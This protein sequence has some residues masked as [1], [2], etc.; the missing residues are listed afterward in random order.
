MA[1]Q[2][3]QDAVKEALSVGAFSPIG[4][5][6]TTNKFIAAGDGQVKFDAPNLDPQVQNVMAT[7]FL[8]LQDAEQTTPNGIVPRPA[9][10][11]KLQASSL[12]SI[13]SYNMLIM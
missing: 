12:S 10:E 5:T 4:A 7:R 1:Q 13:R 9:A 8:K 3:A 6:A 2:I 11:S